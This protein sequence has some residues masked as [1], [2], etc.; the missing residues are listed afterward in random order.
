MQVVRP[1]DADEGEGVYRLHEEPAVAAE[2]LVDLR[3]RLLD[4]VD[5]ARLDRR[6]GCGGVGDH[7][8]LDPIEMRELRPR[9]QA[10]PAV[11]RRAVAAVA[12]IGREAAR[13]VLVGPKAE[14]AAADRLA[15]LL[16]GV[17]AGHAL[18][19]DEGRAAADLPQRVQQQRE[20]LLEAEAQPPVVERGEFLGEGFEL[21][22]DRAALHPAPE[23]L[24]RVRG[25]DRLAVVEEQALAQGD[26]DAAAILLDRVAL[27][28]LRLGTEFGVRAVEGVVHHVAVVAGDVGRGPD[29]VEAGEVGLRHEFQ[30]PAG[31]GL[32]DREARQRRG[33]RRRRRRSEQGSAMHGHLPE[34]ACAAIVRMEVETER[35]RKRAGRPATQAV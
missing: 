14:G 35:R 16:K 5:L 26:R 6:R 19:H 18:R 23:A 22:P 13:I 27:G 9:G 32:R 31:R 8:P 7:V 15:D 1:Q 3:R 2:K 21:L 24:R 33:S 17:G 29:R 34:N 25:A 28:H 30:H 12:L 10:R 4:P 20:G 11:R